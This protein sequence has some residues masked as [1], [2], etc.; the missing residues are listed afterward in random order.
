MGPKN[1][2]EA[3][4]KKTMLSMETKLKIVKK[5]ESGMRSSVI[6]KEYGRNPS[7]IGTILKQK[8]AIKAAT[9]S[10]GVTIFSNKSTLVHDEMERLL[11]VWIK[12]KK[13][14][15]DTITE[16][17]IFQKASAIFGDI[18]R[19]QAKEGASEGTSQ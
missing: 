3:K 2:A 18:V 8:A 4:K 14:S 13:I 9:P 12:D 5:Y 11:L 19:S 15:G 6:A 17:T 16:T 10:K 7:T 1:V